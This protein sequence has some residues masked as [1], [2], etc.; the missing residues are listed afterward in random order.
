MNEQLAAVAARVADV[1]AAVNHVAGVIAALKAERD[2][3]VAA[4]GDTAALQAQINDLSGRLANVSA[5]LNAQ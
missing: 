5:T 1:E 2:A 4:A 3:A